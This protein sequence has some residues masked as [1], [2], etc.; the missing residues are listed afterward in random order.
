MEISIISES[1]KETRILAAFLTQ[2]ILNYHYYC[3]NKKNALIISLEGDLGAGKTEFMKG[4]AESL[5]LKN[6]VLSPTFLIMKN[7]DLPEKYHNN[8]SC[9][10]HLDCY[11]L[12]N[13]K[14]LKSLGF[15]DIIKDKKNLIFIEWGQKIKK[16]LPAKSWVIKFK[17]L[18]KNRRLLTFQI[19]ISK[20]ISKKEF[21]KS[22]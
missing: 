8:F 5:K 18:D 17:T 9:L 12:K 7:I 15:E 2:A 3:L 10:W 14:E 16:L 1:P 13:L 21:S 6:D 11:R 4:I 20:P 19:P 22:N